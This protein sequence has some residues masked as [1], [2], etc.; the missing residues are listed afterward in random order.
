MGWGI[1]ANPALG[2]VPDPLGRG[3]GDHELRVRVFQLTQFQQERVVLGIGGGRPV[4]HV[5]FVVQPIDRGAELIE[6]N[7]DIDETL[8]HARHLP[9]ALDHGL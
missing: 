4:E 9:L 7:L 6:T 8:A 1:S 5:V 2:T 3:L